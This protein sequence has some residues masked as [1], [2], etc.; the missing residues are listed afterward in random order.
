MEFNDPEQV[1]EF[2]AALEVVDGEPMIVVAG[3]VDLGVADRL[4]GCIAS[5]VE[6]GGP[7]VLDFAEVSFIDS[8]G[9][10]LLTRAYHQLGGRPEA[11]VVRRP[12][13]QVRRV[14]EMSGVDGY[15]TVVPASP[16]G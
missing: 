13:P 1:L 7:V 5:V 6:T 16:A 10:N 9:V 12:S 4:W 8:S 3:E 14:L 11:V 15:V 2:R